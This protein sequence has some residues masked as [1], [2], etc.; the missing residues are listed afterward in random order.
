MKNRLILLLLLSSFALVAQ[1]SAE[2]F[3]AKIKTEV[4]YQ[5]LFFKA[6]NDY[7]AKDGKFPLLIFLHWPALGCTWCKSVDRQNRE[8]QPN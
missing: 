7:H 4:K 3:K 1:Q 8:R 6:S 5:Y 2:Q